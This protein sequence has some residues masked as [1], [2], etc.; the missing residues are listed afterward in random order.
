DLVVY[1]RLVATI[2]TVDGVYDVSLD[3]Y[4]AGPDADPHGRSNLSPMPPDTRPRLQAANLDVH[5]RGALIALD[6]SLQVERLGV[7]TIAPVGVALEQ[8]RDDVTQKLQAGLRPAA[9]SARRRWA[10]RSP[11]PRRTGSHSSRTARRS[12]T[13]PS[14]SRKASASHVRTPS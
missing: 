6:A 14:S 8:I 12:S 4:Q 5:L 2:L 10:V 7:A 13:R 9:R 11:T 3:V 1:N